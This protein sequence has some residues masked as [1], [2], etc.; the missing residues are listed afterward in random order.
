M[1]GR[2]TECG[3]YHAD[4][5]PPCESCGN[6][7]FTPVETVKRCVE[8]G[9]IHHGGSPPCDR[10]GT[11][12]F[13]K[14]ENPD[15]GQQNQNDDG[16][17]LSAPSGTRRDVLKYGA[18]LALVAAGSA[19]VLT[20]HDDYPT[21]TAPGEA[22]RA[23]GIRFSTVEAEMKA[24][25]NDERESQGMSAL[26]TAENVDAFATY[27]NKEFVKAGDIDAVNPEE[28]DGQFDVSGHHG[29][30]NYYGKDNTERPINHFDSAS[31][32][33]RDCV[34]S[35][36][37]DSRIRDALL[38]SGRSSVGLDVHVDEA[39]GIFLLAVVA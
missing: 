17:G 23:S 27:Y 20:T 11:M 28:F 1:A 25:I 16:S 13:S 31:E 21:T 24:L 12:A 8:C 37:G 39:G 18:G 30:S 22:E 35:W 15:G 3:H 14:V 26:S 6:T 38:Q 10:C 7:S 36:L 32:L 19:Y 33:A 2:C 34:D 4:S 9:H 5:G 29:A